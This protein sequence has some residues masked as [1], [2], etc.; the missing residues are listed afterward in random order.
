MKRST[1]M[2]MALALLGLLSV[3]CLAGAAERLALKEEIKLHPAPGHKDPYTLF[4]DIRVKSPG[5]IRM[6][7]DPFQVS[8]DKDIPRRLVGIGL[9]RKGETKVIKQE[10]TPSTI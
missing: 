4:Y 8:P 1:L 6:G 7:V 9:V 3:A 10:I 2:V 5:V